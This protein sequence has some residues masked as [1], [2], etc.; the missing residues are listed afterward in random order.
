MFDRDELI[1]RL[2]ADP[3]YRQALKIAGS[4]A[5]RRKIIA[6][7]EGFLTTFFESLSP[8][9]KMAQQDPTLANE[10]KEA[11]NNGKVVRESDGKP[12]VVSGSINK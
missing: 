5:E 2:K 7:T 6:T 4:D 11:I 3:T 12:Y 1:K 8:V 9:I 10:I